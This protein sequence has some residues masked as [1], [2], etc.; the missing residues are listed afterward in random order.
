MTSKEIESHIMSVFFENRP[1]GRRA[2]ARSEK[3][4]K[5]DAKTPRKATQNRA[6]NGP[7][8]GP[9][10]GPAPGPK[11]ADFGTVFGLPKGRSGASLGGPFS[12]SASTSVSKA[13]LDAFLLQKNIPKTLFVCCTRKI[14]PQT[15]HSHSLQ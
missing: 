2:P 15:S 14:L 9:K 13:A 8:G 7:R 3:A 1:L 6:K 4:T 11:P 10:G 5:M 12:K